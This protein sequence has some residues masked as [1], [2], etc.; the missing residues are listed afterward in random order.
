MHLAKQ[1]PGKRIA[2]LNF[3][4]ATNPGGGVVNGSS[5]QEESLCRCSTLYPTLDRRFLWQA[6]YDVNRA[7]GNVLH[8]DACIY[9]P[10]IVV[11]KTDTDFPERLPQE[12]WMTVDVVSCAAPNLSHTPGNLYN[13]ESGQA[14]SIMTSELQRIHEQRARGILAIAATNSVSILVLGAFGCGTFRNAR[15]YANV[16]KDCRQHFDWIEFAIFCRDGERENYDAFA[17]ALGKSSF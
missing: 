6:Y 5:A 13:L 17:E 4:S 10:G 8:T 2:V 14:V 16:L 12:D 3:A 7:A 11:C 15:A 1:H 9:S